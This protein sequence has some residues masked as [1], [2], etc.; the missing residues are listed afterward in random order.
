M[1]LSEYKDRLEER[2]RVGEEGGWI[3]GRLRGARSELDRT[4]RMALIQLAP[5]SWEISNVPVFK[6]QAGKEPQ[7]GGIEQPGRCVLKIATEQ[8][9]Q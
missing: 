3:H 2:S 6:L 8:R 9:G 1:W 5:T 7:V 4:A